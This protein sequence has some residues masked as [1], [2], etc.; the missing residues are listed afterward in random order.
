MAFC[1]SCGAR[2]EGAVPAPVAPPAA[3]APPELSDERKIVSVLFADLV[4]FTSHSEHLDPEDVRHMLRPYYARLR[5]E[6]QRY[7]GTVEKFIGDAVMAL[8]GAPVTHE[9]DA[10]RAVRA[11]LAIRAAMEDISAGGRP[12]HVRIGITTG[13]ALISPNAQTTHGEG[14]AAGDVVNTAARLQSN[15]PV[16]GILVGRA[17]LP[18]HAQRHGVPRGRAGESEGQGRA[19]AGVGGHPAASEPRRRRRPARRLAARGPR[20][21]A[22]IL[23]DALGR[24]RREPH[25]QLVTL[26][27]VPGIGKSRLTAELAA[28]AD[29]DPELIFWRQGRSLPYG[30][31]VTYWALGEMTKAQAGIMATDTAEAA[32]EKLAVAVSDLIPDVSTAQWVESHLRPLVGLAGD[33]VSGDR[34]GEAFAAWRRFFEALADRNSSAMLSAASTARRSESPVFVESAAARIFSSTYTARRATYSGSSVL[35]IGYRC[36]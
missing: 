4:G 1:T 27:G 17:D 23:L 35:R 2:V 15:A 26:V 13:E 21:G 30:E 12:L 32:E 18:G 5:A 11:G 3:A 34:R 24:A 29:A 20:P 31:G 25:A 9:D 36:P 19:S 22:A 16:D 28:A 6:L 10:E 8:F 7:G 33:D 14:M